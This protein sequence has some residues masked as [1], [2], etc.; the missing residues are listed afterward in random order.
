VRQGFGKGDGIL[1]ISLY[2]DGG[3]KYSAEDLHL[4]LGASLP[5]STPIQRVYTAREATGCSDWDKTHTTTMRHAA[6]DDRYPVFDR[7]ANADFGFP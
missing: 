4:M 5:S 3:C 2:Q 7:D 6:R 1:K